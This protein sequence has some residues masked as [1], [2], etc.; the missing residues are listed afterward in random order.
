MIILIPTTKERRPRLQKCLE[1]IWASTIPCM[2]VIYENSGG[3]WVKN[4]HKMLENINRLCF[5]IGDDCVIAPDC[6]EILLKTYETLP[7]KEEWLLQPYERFSEGRIAQMPF[8]HSDILKKYI[9]KGYFQNYSDTELTEV[10]KQRGRYLY[11]PEAKLDHQHF[12]GGAE[13]DET[14]KLSH[15][16]GDEDRILFEKRRANNYED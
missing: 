14:Y 13:Y 2:V 7:N 10:M 16:K 3:G 6:L 4:I 12:M 15:D 9:H 11:V 1:A 8:A 5:C